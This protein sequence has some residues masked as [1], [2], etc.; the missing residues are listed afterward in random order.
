MII[1]GRFNFISLY[2]LHATS[3]I[4]DFF[5]DQQD[6][7]LDANIGKE[8]NECIYRLVHDID[9]Q[10]ATIDEIS[11]YKYAQEIFS[12][13]M[14]KRAKTRHAPGNYELIT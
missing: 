10:D 9:I 1:G 13:E 11:A 4:R 12:S 5:Y 3:L 8:L 6:L 7:F 2:I 14:A